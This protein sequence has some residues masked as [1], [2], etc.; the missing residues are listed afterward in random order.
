MDYRLEEWE[1][2]WELGEFGGN[3]INDVS[4]GSAVI[5]NDVI[6]LLW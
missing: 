6:L 1:S 3:A 5:V 2:G 4:Y